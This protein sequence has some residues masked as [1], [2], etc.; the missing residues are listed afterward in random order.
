MRR[1][2]LIEN[3]RI[4]GSVTIQFDENV[5]SGEYVY[6][7]NVSKGKYE[8]LKGQNTTAL[9]LD[10]EGRYLITDKK[11]SDGKGS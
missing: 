5:V 1:P 2:F 8:L 11:L 10:R 7:Y 6:L 9:Q 4:C 3:V